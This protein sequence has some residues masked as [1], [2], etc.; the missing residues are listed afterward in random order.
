MKGAKIETTTTYI[1]HVRKDLPDVVREKVGAEHANWM[2][3]LQAVHDV[4]PAHL[5]EGVDLWKKK[6]EEQEAIKRRIQQLEKLT[7]S[8]TVALR[9]QITSFNIGNAPASHAQQPRQA[10]TSTMNPFMGT[11][12]GRGNLFQAPQVGTPPQGSVA[13]PPATPADRMALITV[14]QKYPQHLDTDAGRQAHRAQQAEWVKTHGIG[15]FVTESTPYP[16]RPG[17]LSVGSGKCFT[18]GFSG[19]MGKRDGS[20][21][22]G[23]RALHPHEQTWCAIC[24]CIF[25]QTRNIANIQLVAVDDYGTTWQEI[26]GNEDGPLN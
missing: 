14:L 11:A 26:Q 5:K 6:Q 20:T 10:P 16:L 9:Q 15:T 25:R 3:F 1:G 12:G 13:R 23:N 21:C 8:P 22:G 18:C 2:T 7:T 17:T 24:S 19:H 4:D